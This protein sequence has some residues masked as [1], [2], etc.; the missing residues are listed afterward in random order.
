MLL[1]GDFL[2]A[3]AVMASFSFYLELPP[4]QALNCLPPFLPE[5]LSVVPFHP[6]NGHFDIVY[7]A[8]KTEDPPAVVKHSL[9]TFLFCNL[10]W[11][12]FWATWVSHWHCFLQSLGVFLSLTSLLSFSNP[13]FAAY[14]L[15]S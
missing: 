1:K 11:W 15:Q 14:A 12:G 9:N 5:P 6:T 8:Q 13:L 7:C 10:M 2:L 3:P 4:A